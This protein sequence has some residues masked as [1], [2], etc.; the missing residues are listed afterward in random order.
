MAL[1]TMLK[2]FMTF[3]ATKSG[4]DLSTP[5]SYLERTF[6]KSLASGTGAA[7]AD[8]IFH[9]KRTIAATTNDDL[10]LAGSLTDACGATLTF[11]KVKLIYI[12]NPSGNDGDVVVGAAASNQFVGPLGGATHTIAIKPGGCLLLASPVNAGWTVAAGT[13]DI[14]RVR[15]AG[16]ASQ[17]IPVIIVGTSA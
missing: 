5:Q 14:L 10:D 11:A 1:T 16:S 9:D 3:L 6:E 17:D 12:E 15:N 13:G 2:L 4:I 8:L 7:Q